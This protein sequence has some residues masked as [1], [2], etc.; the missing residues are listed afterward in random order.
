MIKKDEIIGILIDRGL[1][2]IESNRTLDSRKNFRLAIIDIEEK[3][4]KEY[5]DNCEKSLKKQ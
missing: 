3:A 2:V 4:V 5:Q 1:S